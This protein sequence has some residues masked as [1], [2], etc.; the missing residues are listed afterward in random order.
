M[1]SFESRAW[2]ITVSVAGIIYGLFGAVRLGVSLDWVLLAG[3]L[4]LFMFALLS[5]KQYQEKM[6]KA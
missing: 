4:A 6:A 1:N 3:A 5:K 2:G